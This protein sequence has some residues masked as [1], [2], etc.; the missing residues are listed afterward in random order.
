MKHLKFPLVALLVAG[1][2]TIA[3]IGCKKDSLT[4]SVTSDAQVITSSTA[5][6]LVLDVFEI[7]GNDPNCSD[8]SLYSFTVNSYEWFKNS[9]KTPNVSDKDRLT[10]T[11]TN[12]QGVVVFS[13]PDATADPNNTTG[14]QTISC[15]P[16]DC[17]TVT[18]HFQHA[19][20]TTADPV[21]LDATLTICVGP[22]S[23]TC[24]FS[25]GYWFANNAHHPNGVHT[26]P[27]NIT[28]GGQ[29]YTEADGLAIWNTSDADGIKDAKK[30]F[31]QL[32]AIYLSGADQTEIAGSVK[33]IED[34]LKSLGTKLS[35][36][37]LP[38]E[39]DDAILQYGDVRDA[40]DA[41]SNYIDLHHCAGDE[42]GQ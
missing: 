26:W 6:R 28:I 17:Y 32:A 30:A 39:S 12:S 4:P 19:A 16:A 18:A 33:T 1:L 11:V 7:T 2:L 21:T 24:T 10:I 31:C 37:N 36:T 34:W 13:Y 29:T 5:F 25:Q 27:N 22:T 42:T 15:V 38:M 23:E 40:A 8:A 20:T 41:I 3:F 9:H 35:P 14:I